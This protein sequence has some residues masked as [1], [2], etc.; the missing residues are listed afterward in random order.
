[1]VER[2]EHADAD[3][4]EKNQFDGNAHVQSVEGPEVGVA[5]FGQ[6]AEHD[7]GEQDLDHRS[8]TGKTITQKQP[9]HPLS[10]NDQ[11]RGQRNGQEGHE[12]HGAQGDVAR[13][14]IVFLNAGPLYELVLVILY[15]Q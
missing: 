3:G 6:G 4:Q 8:S 15:N 12:M 7:S 2:E 11:G 13:L 10:L 5:K 9:R 14:H 1:M